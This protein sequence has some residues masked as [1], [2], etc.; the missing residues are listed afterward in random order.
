MLPG[1]N[2]ALSRSTIHDDNQSQLN[3]ITTSSKS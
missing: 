2:K 1:R 3:N